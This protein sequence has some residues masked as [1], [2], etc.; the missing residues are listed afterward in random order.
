MNDWKHK[1]IDFC[2]K[3]LCHFFFAYGYCHWKNQWKSRNNIHFQIHP[4]Y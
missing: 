4:L 1:M 2:I 3:M